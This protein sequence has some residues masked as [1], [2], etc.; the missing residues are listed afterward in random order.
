MREATELE[1]TVLGVVWLRGP[2]TAYVVRQEFLLSGSAHWSGSAGAIYPLLA[3][4]EQH[5][6]IKA[7]ESEWGRGS[8]KEYSVTRRGMTALRSWIGPPLPEWTA[9]PTFDP[10]R[11]RLSFLGALQ[12]EQRAEFVAEAQRNLERELGRIRALVTS[13]RVQDDPYEYLSLVGT[14]HELEGRQRWLEEVA[15]VVSSYDQ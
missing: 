12:P 10:V 2:C 11:T 5:G 8:K 7:K 3:R 14:V 1:S 13:F 9:A 6:L 15:R 4:L